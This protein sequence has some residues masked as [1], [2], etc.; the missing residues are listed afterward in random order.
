[1]A[2]G[3]FEDIFGTQISFPVDSNPIVSCLLGKNYRRNEVA[4]V[5][6]RFKGNWYGL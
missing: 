2:A 1:M 4:I 3:D 6:R 5:T